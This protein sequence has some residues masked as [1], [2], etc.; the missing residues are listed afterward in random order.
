M[1]ELE[2]SEAFGFSGSITFLADGMKVGANGSFDFSNAS[3]SSTSLLL[4]VW[5]W[6]RLG[7][8]TRIQR[9][10]WYLLQD[11]GKEQRNRFDGNC[12]RYQNET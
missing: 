8:A 6:E 9:A 7:E 3:K 4:I 11:L 12:C 1:T 10:E 5:D 2:S